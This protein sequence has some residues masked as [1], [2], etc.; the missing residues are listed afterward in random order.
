R[1]APAGALAPGSEVVIG[2]GLPGG[3]WVEITSTLRDEA[4]HDH[5]NWR[6][7]VTGEPAV[8]QR[9]EYARV[10]HMAV[11]RI[12]INGVWHDTRMVDLSEGGL[13]CTVAGIALPD[14]ESAVQVE[15]PIATE[16]V[17]L[18]AAVV[19][20]MT[21]PTGEAVVGTRFA[22]VDGRTADRIRRE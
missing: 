15:L 3:S 20:S 18:D 12:R 14:P 9:R 19:R 8:V 22:A 2:W 10:L 11:M 6:V 13:A 16:K 1:G 4:K 21:L 7:V 17:T 5:P